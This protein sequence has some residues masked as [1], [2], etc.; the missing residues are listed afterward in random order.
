MNSRR[1]ICNPQGSK[2]TIEIEFLHARSGLASD[3]VQKIGALQND[4]A[5]GE[6]GEGL[7]VR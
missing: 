1:L 7:W 5:L 4:I 6:A 2:D 3:R